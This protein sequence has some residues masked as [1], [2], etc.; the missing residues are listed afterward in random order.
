MSLF[1]GCPSIAANGWRYVVGLPCMDYRVTNTA[2]GK[3]KYT[4]CCRYVKN[5]ELK[6]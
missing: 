3:L 2:Y 4:A 5:T 6:H 1:G